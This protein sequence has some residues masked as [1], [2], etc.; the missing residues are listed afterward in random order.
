MPLRGFD[1]R[2][3][4]AM[5]RR[6]GILCVYYCTI[7][8]IRFR[9]LHPFIKVGRLNGARLFAGQKTFQF[10]GW[11]VWMK[12]FNPGAGLCLPQLTDSWTDGLRL[13]DWAD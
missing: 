3:D 10:W 4:H 1:G 6:Y 5:L 12:S 2:A 11:V 9:I 7:R 13:T 8:C